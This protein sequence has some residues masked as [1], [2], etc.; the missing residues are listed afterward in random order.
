MAGTFIVPAA[1]GQISFFSLGSGI[2]TTYDITDDGSFVA[3]RTYPGYAGVRWSKETGTAMTVFQGDARGISGDGAIIVGNTTAGAGRWTQAQGFTLFQASNAQSGVVGVSSDGSTAVGTRNGIATRWDG[4]IPQSLGLLPGGLQ[5][6][7]T[8]ISGDGQTIVG[9]SGTSNSQ[10]IHAFRWTETEGMVD[11][12]LM[13]NFNSRATAVSTDGS[14]IVGYGVPLPGKSGLD[15]WLRSDSGTSVRL[16]LP[17][18]ELVPTGV[19]DDGAFVAGSTLGS[20]NFG[21]A[22]L[23][24]P[25]SGTRDFRSVM[26]NEYGFATEIADWSRLAI[27]AMSSDGRYLIGSGVHNGVSEAW[28]LDRGITPPDLLPQ[29]P[30]SAVPEPGV[31]GTAAALLLVGAIGCRRF[32]K[33]HREAEIL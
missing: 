14:F 31:I 26:T 29:A 27:D 5:S 2:T 22:F 16:H 33:L 15:G 1:S 13:G 21:G 32:A 28:M 17:S 25:Q 8:A 24:T 30:F 18:L 19:S 11:I 3:G 12:G 6:E 20:M 10:V 4:L 23:W 9:A 7:A